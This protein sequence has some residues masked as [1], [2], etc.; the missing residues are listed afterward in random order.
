MALNKQHLQLSVFDRLDQEAAFG[1][2]G[3]ALADVEV[4]RKSV[5]RDVENLLNTRRCI[6]K[7]T[8]SQ[9]YLNRSLYVYGL[10]DFVAQNPKSAQVQKLLEVT[11]R[12][13][14]EKFEPRLTNVQVAL[15]PIDDYEHNLCFTVRATLPA[16]PIREPISFD[17]W[18]SA[19]RGEYR[20]ENTK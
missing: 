11:I 8:E 10:D 14:I 3:G 18:F 7:P 13:T 15:R 6:V 2:I 4:V 9:L 16:D 5:L 20:I 1:I 19:S 12:D 17:T